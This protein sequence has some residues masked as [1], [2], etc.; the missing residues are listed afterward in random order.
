[1]ERP[2]YSRNDEREYLERGYWRDD[3]TLAHWL[4]RHAAERPDA[5]AVLA[6]GTVVTWRELQ[7]RVL[8]V[9]QGLTEKGIGTGDIVAVQLPNTLEFL[10]VHL[11]AARLGAVMCTVHMPYRGAEIETIL[12]HSGAKLFFTA[13]YPFGE[14]VGATPLPAEHP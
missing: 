1:M 10:L 6:A 2:G 8:C 14:L 3:D 7:S 11:A 4:A 12:G 13:A 5:P 9:A